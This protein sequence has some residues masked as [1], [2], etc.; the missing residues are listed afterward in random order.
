MQK[1]NG[2]Q[3]WETIFNAKQQK[4]KATMQQ[5]QQQQQ[6]QNDCGTTPSQ[7]HKLKY[8]RSYLTNS[9]ETHT[10]QSQT[11]HGASARCILVS[12]FCSLKKGFMIQ[13][14]TKSTCSTSLYHVGRNFTPYTYS[15][16]KNWS[17]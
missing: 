7:C 15:F 8:K 14:T 11:V 4:Q 9:K 6:N 17:S 1:L 13:K 12:I 5:H 2:S 16:C 3:Q 10:V